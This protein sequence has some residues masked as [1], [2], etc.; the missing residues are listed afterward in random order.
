MSN[1]A[2]QVA[3]QSILFLV[4]GLHDMDVGTKE[5][6]SSEEGR[7]LALSLGCQFTEVSAEGD[8]HLQTALYDMARQLGRR[9]LS[10]YTTQ[11]VSLDQGKSSLTQLGRLRANRD[12]HTSLEEYWQYGNGGLV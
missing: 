11:S 8:G 1:Q 9:W 2:N 7:K 5:V 6:V 12:R 3:G 10:S 4:V